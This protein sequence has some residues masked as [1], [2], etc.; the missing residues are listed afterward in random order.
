[1]I[2]RRLCLIISVLNE[3]RLTIVSETFA[4]FKCDENRGSWKAQLDKSYRISGDLNGK[5]Y[6]VYHSHKF[7]REICVIKYNSY[8]KDH[9]NLLIFDCISM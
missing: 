6:L 7:N 8:F 9:N 4:T 3:C 1:M 2:G 5:G